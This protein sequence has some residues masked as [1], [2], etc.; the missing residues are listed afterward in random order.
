MKGV[1]EQG[2]EAARGEPSPGTA[3]HSLLTVQFTHGV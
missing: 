3:G 2:A 1:Q